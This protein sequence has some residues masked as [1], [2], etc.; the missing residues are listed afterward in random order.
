APAARLEAT[1][2]TAA[3]VLPSPPALE[4]PAPTLAAEGPSPARPGARATAIEPLAAQAPATP[5]LAPERLPTPALEPAAPLLRP[6]SAP[7]PA[8]TA[9]PAAPTLASPAPLAAPEPSSLPATSSPSP[10]E[11]GAA[12]AL[13]PQASPAPT[14]PM[15][16]GDP[17]GQTLPGQRA[18]PGSPDAG[19]QLGH[20]VAT[21]PSAPA[22]AVPTPLNLN[23]PRRSGPLLRQGS[24]L[25]Q[26]LPGVPDTRSKM[27]KAIEEA[28]REDCRKAH[29]DKGLL[30][31]AALAADALRGKGC[32]W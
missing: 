10:R 11:P 9:L 1:R 13:P 23:L 2:P 20:D 5:V 6:R 15:S 12:D 7:L 18:S 3:A 17:Q 29:A 22:S 16:R 30:G 14:K 26:I 27:E 19:P 21:A 4:L 25:I 24:S 8:P 31:A 28:N 32:K